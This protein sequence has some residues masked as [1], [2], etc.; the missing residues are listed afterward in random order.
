[1]RRILCLYFTWYVLDLISSAGKLHNNGKKDAKMS[2]Q[3]FT[4][5][6]IIDCYNEATS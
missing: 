3:V 4:A 5:V 1:M 2:L 6:E